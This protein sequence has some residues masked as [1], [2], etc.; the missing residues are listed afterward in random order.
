MVEGLS[1]A[2]QFREAAEESNR[3]AE[4]GYFKK[5][6]LAKIGY[7]KQESEFFSLRPDLSAL[8]HAAVRWIAEIPLRRRMSRAPWGVMTRV[9]EVIETGR[10]VRL[11]GETYVIARKDGFLVI[12][13]HLAG[14]KVQKSY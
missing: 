6:G 13:N 3:S 2:D 4:I 5:G 1:T 7:S 11:S 12:P 14:D 10:L 8:V 9:G